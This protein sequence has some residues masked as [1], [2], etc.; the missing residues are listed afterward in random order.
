MT[1]AQNS[2]RVTRQSSKNKLV[3]RTLRSRTVLASE[4]RKNRT[5]RRKLVLIGTFRRFPEKE[6]VEVRKNGPL[7]LIETLL[8]GESSIQ[9][10][11][12]EDMASAKSM[13]FT[14]PNPVSFIRNG[15]IIP[16]SQLK[17]VV[18]CLKKSGVLIGNTDKNESRKEFSKVMLVRR[19]ME[20]KDITSRRESHSEN[21]LIRRLAMR[22]RC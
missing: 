1:K 12:E 3:L 10:I 7:K 2:V 5:R 19:K 18:S 4:T 9:K 14:T 8:S 16:T 22:K 21:P 13:K 15:T 6:K 11:F 17:Q 20:K